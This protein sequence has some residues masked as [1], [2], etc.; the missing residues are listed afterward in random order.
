MRMPEG[1][2]PETTTTAPLPLDSPVRPRLLTD[3]GAVPENAVYELRPSPSPVDASDELTF[4]H[5][6]VE[7]RESGGDL[8]GDLRADLN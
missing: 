2:P 5:L 8:A 7:I 4:L 3:A 1:R 6:I